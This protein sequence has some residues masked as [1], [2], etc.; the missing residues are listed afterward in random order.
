MYSILADHAT[1]TH[2]SNTITIL[3]H[4]DAKVMVNGKPARD[5]MEIHHNDRFFFVF[6]FV[7]FTFVG[8]FFTSL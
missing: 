2:K 4:P 3:A 5:E 1:V 6:V 7:L 8:W